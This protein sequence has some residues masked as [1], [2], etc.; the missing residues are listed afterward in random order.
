MSQEWWT[1]KPLGNSLQKHPFLLVLRRYGRYG[2]FRRL[3]RKAR[4]LQFDYKVI[5]KIIIA[6]VEDHS[7]RIT[8]KVINVFKETDV[9][10]VKEV[11]NLPRRR[12]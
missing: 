7:N 4:H 8:Q 3:V 11:H 1:E 6:F 10:G 12:S 2:C 9:S 5:I